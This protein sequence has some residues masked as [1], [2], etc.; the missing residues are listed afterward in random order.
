MALASLT[1]SCRDHDVW[2]CLS[3]VQFG[4]DPIR[5]EPGFQEL[6]SRIEPGPLLEKNER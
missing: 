3:L 6:L 1:Q 5:S 2:L 4:Q